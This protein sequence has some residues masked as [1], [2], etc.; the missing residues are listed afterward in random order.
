MRSL[1]FIFFVMMIMG[2]LSCEKETDPQYPDE[3]QIYYNGI[4]NTHKNIFDSSNVI[5]RLGFNDGDG[6]L[7][8]KENDSCITLT[9]YRSD[10]IYN[11]FPY[12]F[13]LIGKDYRSH[14]WL[15]GSFTITL[16]PAYFIPR[17]DSLH[18]K[19]GKDTLYYKIYITDEAGHRSNEI[20]TDTI[21]I[22]ND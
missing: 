5:I 12:G 14:S 1:Q 18:T 15:E 2:L 19:E 16:Q 6:D 21:Y 8:N 22:F 20:Q 3:P 17:P 7:G 4:S 10:T 13:P 11:S 9:E